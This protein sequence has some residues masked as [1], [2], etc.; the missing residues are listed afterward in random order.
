VLAERK[1]NSRGAGQGGV[2]A[3]LEN[4]DA[5]LDK[6]R[7]AYAEF[8]LFSVQNP[9]G[10]AGLLDEGLGSGC[11][12]IA[13]WESGASDEGT[14]ALAHRWRRKRR[15]L[16]RFDPPRDVVTAEWDISLGCDLGLEVVDLQSWAFRDGYAGPFVERCLDKVRVGG[17][18]TGF[19]VLG[20]VEC[21]VA[22]LCGLVSDGYQV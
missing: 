14:I 17:L 1:A 6:C 20:S 5:H 8:W 7:Y 3:L 19:C 11:E 21:S 22:E 13:C 4:P 16:A 10:F 18:H 15:V 9:G 12:W 2:R